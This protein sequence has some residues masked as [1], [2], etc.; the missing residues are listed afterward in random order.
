MGHFGSL[1]RISQAARAEEGI[2]PPVNTEHKIKGTIADRNHRRVVTAS[3]R[4]ANGNP[5]DCSCFLLTDGD[6]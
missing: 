5:R 1:I 2:G 4:G 3:G 6:G